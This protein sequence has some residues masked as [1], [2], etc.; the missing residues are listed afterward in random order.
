MGK[1]G[2]TPV[3]HELFPKL[4]MSTLP[5]YALYTDF[6]LYLPPIDVC[7]VFNQWRI[8]KFHESGPTVS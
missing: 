2:S 4:S 3:I 7:K 6:L 1:R 8:Q 5:I